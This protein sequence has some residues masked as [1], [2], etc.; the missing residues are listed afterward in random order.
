[1]KLQNILS[2]DSTNFDVP[3]LRVFIVLSALIAVAV[4]Q[5]ADPLAQ[6]TPY[7]FSYNSNT[8]DGGSSG[9]QESGD[10]SGR[11]SGSYTVTDLEG[12]SR[13]VDYVADEL[14]FRATVRTNEP[15][16]ANLNS[17]DVTMESSGDDNGI[18]AAYAGNIPAPVAPVAPVAGR[19]GVRYVL[20]P[21]TDPRARGYY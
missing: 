16:T 12:H 15:G 14:G 4:S 6:P 10:G 7:S 5:L 21:V 19:P 1:M 11:V 3:Y 9:H 8:E 2:S 17:A 18:A 20:V 13:V